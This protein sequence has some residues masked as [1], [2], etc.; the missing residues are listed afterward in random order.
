LPGCGLFR[1]GGEPPIPDHPIW[2]ADAPDPH[3]DADDGDIGTDDI[4]PVDS[5]M[6]YDASLDASDT[7]GVTDG[8][9]DTPTGSMTCEMEP[10]LSGMIAP[11]EY[12]VCSP[13]ESLPPPTHDIPVYLGGGVLCEDRGA[14]AWFEVN[15][16]RRLRIGLPNSPEHLTLGIIDPSIGDPGDRLI[17]V[18]GHEMN[19]VELLFGPGLLVLE[20]ISTEPA[21]T[22]AYFEFAID[23]VEDE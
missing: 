6:P 22:S 15:E 4:G 13:D 8:D 21:P 7:D 1:T 11:P 19:C 20:A 14:I 12:F 10:R 5:D 16:R 9:L 2:D 23:V 18:V 17:A 3:P